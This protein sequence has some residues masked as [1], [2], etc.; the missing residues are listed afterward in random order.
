MAISLLHRTGLSAIDSALGDLVGA[1][2]AAFPGRIEGHYLIGSFADG[3]A[4]ATSD[5]DLAIVFRDAV[6]PGEARRAEELAASVALAIPVDLDVIAGPALLAGGA[7]LAAIR[8]RTAGVPLHGT[9]RRAQLPL[10]ALADYRRLV[11]AG[12]FVNLVQIIRGREQV[13]YPLDYPDPG[14]PFLGY[15]VLR[16]SNRYS[17]DGRGMKDLVAGIGWAATALVALRTGAY[18]GG[19][20]AALRR[21]RDDIGDGWAAL[22]E[23]CYALCRRR[24]AYRLP[25]DPAGRASLRDLCLR[26]LAFENHYFATYRDFLLAEVRGPDP[27]ARLAAVQRLG[28][29]LYRDREVQ[30]AV[31]ACAD[32][33]EP[34]LAPAATATLARLRAAR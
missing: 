29:V 5:L 32:S 21:Y 20:E 23:E 22:L 34:G 28:G 10:P 14:G 9:D 4:V 3:T 11:T 17:P 12:P 27:A 25:A 33:A 24:W 2:D 26:L 18:V 19:K 16:P 8:L 13:A 15:D 1:L 31:A 6:A 7:P 30:A